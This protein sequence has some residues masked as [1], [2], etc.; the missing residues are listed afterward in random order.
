VDKTLTID[1]TEGR[2]TKETVQIFHCDK[3]TINISGKV[4]KIVLG[5][6]KKRNCLVSFPHLN[7][8]FLYQDNAQFLWSD[9]KS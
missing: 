8:R 6:L 1:P 9:G 2:S 4:N 5:E 3:C 7:T